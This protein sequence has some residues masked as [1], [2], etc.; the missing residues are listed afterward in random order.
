ME[1]ELVTTPAG[2][3][4]DALKDK[5][6]SA[7]M[8]GAEDDERS[9]SSESESGQQPARFGK[10]ED[11]EKEIDKLQKVVEAKKAGDQ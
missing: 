11:I 3:T 9:G 1:A 6:D 5:I 7:R 4:A 10:K 2:P 8:A